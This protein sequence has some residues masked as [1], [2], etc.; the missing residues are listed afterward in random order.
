L[1][2][3]NRVND[4]TG[5]LLHSAHTADLLKEAR[6]GWLLKAA[7]EPGE[8]RSPKRVVMNLARALMKASLAVRASTKPSHAGL[9]S[10]KAVSQGQTVAHES[11]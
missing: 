10:A 3:E 1:E 5:K 2:E 8:S 6:G 7:Q 11:R 9:P 4:Y